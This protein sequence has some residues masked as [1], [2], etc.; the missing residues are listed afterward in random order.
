MLEKEASTT[1]TALSRQQQLEAN[2]LID[3]A[4]KEKDPEIKRQLLTDAQTNQLEALNRLEQEQKRR[5][6]L[7]DIGDIAQE[8]GIAI[9]SP[10]EVLTTKTDRINEREQIGIALLE[11]N[12][13]IKNIDARLLTAKGKEVGQLQEQRDEALALRKQLLL[14]QEE[15][16]QDLTL[17]ANKEKES[18]GKGIDQES[19][20]Y[21]LTYKEELEVASS[22]QYRELLPVMLKLEN[23]QYELKV[24]EQQLNVKKA[25]LTD[26]TKNQS[27]DA[28]TRT[29]IAKVLIEIGDLENDIETLRR[30]INAQQGAINRALPADPR[31]REIT[32]NLLVRQVTPVDKTPSLPV[33]ASGL[34][35]ATK[36]KPVYN[37]DNPIPL[38]EDKPKGLYF[39]VQI[40][41]FS[42]PVP[43]NTFTEFA[44]LSGEEVRPGLIRYMAGFFGGRRDAEL[45]RDEIRKMGYS[46]AFVVA[47]CDGERIPV[48][49]AEQLIASGA[50]VPTIATS[51]KPVYTSEEAQN[52]DIGAGGSFQEELDEFAYN[53]APGAAEATAAE[54]LMGLYFTVQVGVYN[55][56]VSPAQLNNISPLVTK[57]LPNGQIRYS[58]GMFD[59]VPDAQVK[60]TEAVN[61]GITDAFIVAYFKG[62]RITVAQARKLLEEHGEEI[63]ESR[64]PTV[65][66]RNEVQTTITAAPPAPEPVL[67]GKQFQ[68]QLVSKETYFDYP[69]QVMHRFNEN[70]GP[71]YFD[72]STGT[73]R[74]LLYP[75]NKVPK[76]AILKAELDEI[77][78]YNAFPVKDKN[79]VLWENAIENSS[80]TLVK[81]HINVA[82]ND[83]TDDIVQAFLRAQALKTLT[84]DASGLRMEIMVFNN[85]EYLD[86]LQINFARLGATEIKRSSFVIPKSKN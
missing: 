3:Q 13:Q 1:Q 8:K 42:R 50:C 82:T 17:I 81:L 58:S 66:K 12:D 24:K 71:F 43:N 9:S 27:G 6:A 39:R 34:V 75:E 69:T 62:E 57:R 33:M 29:K 10:E 37:E 16:D 22:E 40:G 45:A 44:P 79:A 56:P 20:T 21:E 36:D 78:Y 83:I 53:K 19:K 51:E 5:Q 54:T 84:I 47:Y 7:I 60:R 30:E 31:E 74:S 38:N 15:L 80:D 41:A 65:K 35:L 11:I 70:G 23:K 28:E 25:E 48:Y 49:R 55:K 4:N 73:I 86:K 26:L 68:I 52:M 77:V 63:L 2:R 64:N 72:E 32:Q 18:K 59:N 61:L 46:D 76:E 14:R 85:E 67:S